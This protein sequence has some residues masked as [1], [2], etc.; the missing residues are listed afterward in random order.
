M[1]ASDLQLWNLLVPR[2]DNY[3]EFFPQSVLD[4]LGN[5]IVEQAGGYTYPGTSDSV[6]YYK[7]KEEDMIKDVLMGVHIATDLQTIT[8]IACF[9]KK[10]LGQESVMF[11]QVS[12]HVFF[13]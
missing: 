6:G 5:Y 8:K 11:Y 12:P 7:T 13:V 2:N 1:N 10:L 4:N 3:G 9:A